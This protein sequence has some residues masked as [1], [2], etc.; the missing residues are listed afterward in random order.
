MSILDE[1]CVNT[2]RARS[3]DAVEK[4]HSGHPGMPLGAAT[5]AYVVWTR[6]LRHNPRDPNWADRDRF[7]GHVH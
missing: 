1:L 3:I 5:M 2:I 6:F 7:I 4:A